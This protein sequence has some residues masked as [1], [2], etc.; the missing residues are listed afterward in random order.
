MNP[1]PVLL[2]D[3]SCGFCQA[4]VQFVLRRDRVGTLRFAP[5]AGEF[6]SRVRDRHPELATIDSVVWVGAASERA[7]VRSEAAMAVARYLGWP[8]RMMGIFGVVPR[9]LRDLVYDAVARRRHRLA[10]RESCLMP[11]EAE[12]VRFLP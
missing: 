6:G 10:P 8:W 9:R 3:G 11:T 7:L 1:W 2:Y 12:R 4:T 5:L